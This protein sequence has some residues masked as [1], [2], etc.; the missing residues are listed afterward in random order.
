MVLLRDEL[1]VE[2]PRDVEG[3]SDFSVI[4]SI[5]RTVSM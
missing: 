2:G 1:D 5:F 3:N 4:L